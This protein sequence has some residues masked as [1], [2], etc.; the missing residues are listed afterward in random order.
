MSQRNL[1]TSIISAKFLAS[2]TI[3]LVLVGCATGGTFG[4]YDSDD[5]GLVS[6]SEADGRIYYFDS[7]DKNKD[8][9]LDEEEFKW[10]HAASKHRDDKKTGV[11]QTPERNSGGILGTGGGAG[12][13]GY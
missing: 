9:G 12:A 5:D 4:G 1:N 8:G 11:N 13:G 10:A 2:A 6:K 7:Y 3:A